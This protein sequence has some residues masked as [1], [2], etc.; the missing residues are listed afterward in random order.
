MDSVSCPD[1]AAAA[2]PNSEVEYPYILANL[3]YPS[4]EES[5]RELKAELA[6][7]IL[8]PISLLTL[9]HSA[10]VSEPLNLGLLSLP[11][12]ALLAPLVQQYHLPPVQL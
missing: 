10:S 5:A 2:S 7:S 8:C 3:A 12:P 4:D 11:P 9:P 6:F 1:K